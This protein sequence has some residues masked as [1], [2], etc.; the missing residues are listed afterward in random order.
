MQLSIKPYFHTNSTW[1]EFGP[2]SSVYECDFQSNLIFIQTQRG[3]SSGP[4]RVCMNATFDQT[5]F[6]YKLCVHLIFPHTLQ[7]PRIFHSTQS[8][9]PYFHTSPPSTN[10]GPAPHPFLFD[11]TIPHPTYSSKL[12]HTS[13]RLGQTLFSYNLIP[14]MHSSDSI[15]YFSSFSSKPYFHTS[16]PNHPEPTFIVF[17]SIIP[18]LFNNIILHCTYS[19]TH[20]SI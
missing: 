16:S 1:V 10:V 18:F 9:K 2:R 6:L 19:F 4:G 11:D 12:T 5:L 14:L 8:T 20:T 17:P 7:D 13:V 3:S 15:H